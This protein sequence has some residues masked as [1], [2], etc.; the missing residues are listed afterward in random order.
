MIRDLMSQRALVGAYKIGA[1]KILLQT[2]EAFGSHSLVSSPDRCWV[3]PRGHMTPDP[4]ELELLRSRLRGDLA[5]PVSRPRASLPRV[6]TV[7]VDSGR[8][9][10][11]QYLGRR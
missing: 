7:D 8:D 3:R 10:C 5:K 9:T 6:L 11:P 4:V 1:T 2:F